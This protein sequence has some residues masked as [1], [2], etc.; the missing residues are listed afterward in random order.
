MNKMACD[1]Q[2]SFMRWDKPR[3]PHDP[4]PYARHRT[5]L[6][7]RVRIQLEALL[8]VTHRDRG[9]EHFYLIAP[10]RTEWVNA[11]ERL[12]QIPSREF[13]CVYSQDR[14]RSLGRD[15]LW[16]GTESASVPAEGWELEIE[17]QRFANTEVHES[18]SAI[19]AATERS[20]PLVGRTKVLHP[21]GD[22][23]CTL[24]YP[25]KTMNFRPETPTFQVDTGPL[26]LPD[27]NSDD[28]LMIDRLVMAHVAYNRLD[29]AEFIIRRPTPIEAGDTTSGPAALHYSE[30]LEYQA[31]N[32]IL[33]SGR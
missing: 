17:I 20:A 5:P 32:Q 13:R 22:Y 31:Y 21:D 30:V 25:I 26:V 28:E 33:T 27:F 14:E 8:E 7:N 10:C 16:S 19:T 2:R 15:L 6:G 12:F 29:R 11:P 23:E 4:R 18:I 1:F 3:N 24:E 9:S